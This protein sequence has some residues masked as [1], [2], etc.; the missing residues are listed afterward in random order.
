LSGLADDTAKNLRNL[1]LLQ[2]N[3]KTIV[4]TSSNIIISIDHCF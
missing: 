2:S 4:F 3:Y 1:R